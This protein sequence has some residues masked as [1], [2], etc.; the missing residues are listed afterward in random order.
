VGRQ[1]Q[2]GLAVAPE[3]AGVPDGT[4][5]VALSALAESH[6]VSMAMTF[7]WWAEA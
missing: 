7:S 6:H 4:T 1:D 3:L 5:F 2:P